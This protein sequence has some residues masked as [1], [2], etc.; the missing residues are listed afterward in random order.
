MADRFWVGGGSSNA[1]SAT[2]NTNWSATSGGANNASVPG[3]SDNAI[4]DG[5]SGAG[6][7]SIGTTTRSCI[8]FDASASGNTFSGS[9]QV[10]ISGSLTLGAGVTWSHTGLWNFTS[11]ASGRTITLAG[12]TLGGG[13]TFNGVGGVWTL[14]DALSATG[15]LTLT[16]GSLDANAKAVT[17]GAISTANANTRTL[18]LGGCAI[19]LTGS[20]TIW[21]TATTTGLTLDVSSASLTSNYSGINTRTITAGSLAI[22]ANIA[23]TAGSG[24]FS[25]TNATPTNLDFTGFTGPMQTGAVTIS[26]NLTLGSGMSVPSTTNALT[27]TGNCTLTS[28]GVTIDR[29]LTINA[30]SSTV[31]LADNLTLGATRT[32]LLTAGTFNTANFDVDCG[33]LRVAGNTTRTLTMGSSDI[34]VRAVDSVGGPLRA[35]T[36][37]NLTITANTATLHVIGGATQSTLT[38]G[39]LNWNGMSVHLTGGGAGA[40]R[41]DD[42]GT[43]NGMT[44]DTPPQT[45]L[46]ESGQTFT[47]SSWSGDGTLGNL[48]TLGSSTTAAHNLVKAGGGTVTLAYQDISYSDASPANDWIASDGTSVNT[49]NN[50]GWDFGGVAYT[51]E[52]DSSAIPVNGTISNLRVLHNLAAIASALAVLADDSGLYKSFVLAA[53]SQQIDVQA[54]ASLLF[55]TR[56]IVADTDSVLISGVDISLLV[57]RYLANLSSEM[58]IEGSDLTFRGWLAAEQMQKSWTEEVTAEKIWTEAD[59]GATSWTESNNVD[60]D[61]S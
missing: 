33:T 19:T 36:S 48:M 37:T 2:G 23:V 30:P 28:N 16:N 17:V 11:T 50:T 46:F 42:S 6:T 26:G 41:M 40:F 52:L 22:P 60:T 8:N 25:F 61:W 38:C 4:F 44:R 39:G 5:N 15:T 58:R 7:V 56:K 32:L 43:F 9:S 51:F 29:P 3:A 45:L 12:K 53:Q 21:T 34:T 10:T 47:F 35:T 13:I 27:L 55:P 18:D 14:Q 24:S 54:D 59:S 1:W 31:Q 57:Q 49:G 20:G